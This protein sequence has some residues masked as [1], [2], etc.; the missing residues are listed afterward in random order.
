MLTLKYGRS[1]TQSAHTSPENLNG[2]YDSQ[3][4]EQIVLASLNLRSSGLHDA[5]RK[6]AEQVR[7]HEWKEIKELRQ[8]FK[9]QIA[10]AAARDKGSNWSNN[11][12]RDT[13]SGFGAV[14]ADND[15]Y[16]RKSEPSLQ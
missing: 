4:V 11:S 7:Q 2:C 15:K 12:D 14:G 8:E 9:Q 13:D 16:E 10:S 3:R 6:L 5:V 1:V